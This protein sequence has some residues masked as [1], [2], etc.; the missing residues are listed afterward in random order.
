HSGSI[1][2]ESGGEG[3]GATF[4]VNLPLM[5]LGKAAQPADA[6]EPDEP[7]RSELT[8][9]Q[10]LIVEDNADTREFLVTLLQQAGAEVRAV[11]SVAEA[12][13]CLEAAMPNVIVSDIGMPEADGYELMRRIQTLDVEIPAI[14]LTAYAKQ[15]E[16]HKALTAGFQVHLPKPVEPGEL[17][18]S[19]AKLAAQS[20]VQP[21]M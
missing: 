2:A 8:G 4:T 17:L 18:S 19:V 20:A 10:V 11:A 1:S 21:S 9:V 6:P 3:Q 16:K 13:Q 5:K 15:E 7:A 12:M 14:A